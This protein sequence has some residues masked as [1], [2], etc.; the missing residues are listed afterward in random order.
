MELLANTLSSTNNVRVQYITG[1][2][3]AYYTM[4]LN[5]SGRNTENIDI[6]MIPM[7]YLDSFIS[8]S[9]TFSLG[10]N[11]RPYFHPSF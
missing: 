4:L 8:R 5:N 7:D 10:E 1:D 2:L 6:A 11:L 3:S 9:A